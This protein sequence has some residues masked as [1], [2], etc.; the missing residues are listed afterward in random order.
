LK[1]KKRCEKRKEYATRKGC[2]RKS[3]HCIGG[4]GQGGDAAGGGVIESGAKLGARGKTVK[5]KKERNS[6]PEDLHKRRE[7]WVA[8]NLRWP[9]RGG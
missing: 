3:Q 8:K 2:G 6:C 4:G 7:G 1:G 9:C 5:K